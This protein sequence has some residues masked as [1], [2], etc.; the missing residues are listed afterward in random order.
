M[1]LV[2]IGL[3]CLAIAAGV[4]LAIRG[5]RA[6]ALDAAAV[7]AELDAFAHDL[8]DPYDERLDVP[9]LPRLL[10]PVGQHATRLFRGLLPSARLERLQTGLMRAGITRLGP[11]EFIA[12][13]LMSL[14]AGGAFLALI[15]TVAGWG[16]AGLTRAV[17]IGAV[18]GAL[19]PM[20]WLQRKRDARV[21]TV[22]RD[23]PDVLDLMAISVE[24]GVGLEGAIEV[25]TRWSW[26]CPAAPPCRTCAIASPY[27]R[28]PASCSR[29]CK[30]TRSGC[31]CLACCA[32]SPRRCGCAA[33][34]GRASAPRACRS[35]SCS[36]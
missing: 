1:D 15:A 33:G 9:L 2:W 30:P 26:G 11:E 13:Q 17:V 8:A 36:R 19:V 34:N 32:R 16:P 10:H 24:A 25:V 6:P 23:L 22:R 18:L 5:A 35:R 31:R 4:V 12:V 29:S 20:Q 28:S 14:V 27:R 21:L 7:L 3:G